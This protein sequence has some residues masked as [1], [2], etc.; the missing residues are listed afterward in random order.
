M[1]LGGNSLLASAHVIDP[2]SHPDAVDTR[3]MIVWHRH[4]VVATKLTVQTQ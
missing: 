3:Q 4:T 2:P 1:S